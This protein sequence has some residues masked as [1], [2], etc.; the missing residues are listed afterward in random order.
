MTYMAYGRCRSGQR[1][2]WFA[3]SLDTSPFGTSS[4]KCDDPVCDGGGYAQHLYGWEGSEDLALEVMTT[5]VAALGGEVNATKP[6]GWAGVASGALKRINGA[7]R[8]ARPPSNETGTGVV[9]YLYEAD[10]YWP[11]EGSEVRKVRPW[12]IARKTAKRIYFPDGSYVSREDLEGDTRCP[13]DCTARCIHGYGSPH[14][15]PPGEM[16]K[17]GRS[18][19]D[20]AHLFAT[21]EAAEVYLFGGARDQARKREGRVPGLKRLKQEMADAHPDRGGTDEEFMT[22]RQRYKQALREA[23]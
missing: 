20:I 1:W 18:W 9:E 2:F 6:T 13:G 16:L 22:A 15:H 8:S 21:R 23:S 11:E 12:P 10:V 17:G 14:G 5:A 19:S 3:G 4:H 7:R